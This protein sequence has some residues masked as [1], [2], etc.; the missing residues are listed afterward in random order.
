MSPFADTFEKLNTY[1]IQHAVEAKDPSLLNGK[2]GIAVYFFHLARYSHHSSY[3]EFAEVLMDDVYT[4]IQKNKLSS[5]FGEGLAGIAWAIDHLVQEQFVEA[6]IDEVLSEVDDRIYSFLCHSKKIEFG[7][8]EGI[9]GYLVYVIIR[10]KGHKANNKEI[11]YVFSQ[12]FVELINRLSQS[13]DEKVWRFLEP[14][15]FALD[16]DLPICLVLLGEARALN[17]Y[18]DKIERMIS[19]LAPTVLAYTPYQHVH[20]LFLSL[21]ILHL[22][23]HFDLPQWKQHA[24]TILSHFDAEA[25]LNKELKEKNLFLA[26]GLAG[27]SF[28]LNFLNTQLETHLHLSVAISNKIENSLF[29]RS[30]LESEID[31]KPNLGLVNGLAGIG[32]QYLISRQTKVSS[33]L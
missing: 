23:R 32:L 31:K 12:V 2:M 27:I 8:R 7:L 13:I 30:Q 20:K 9:L 11:D 22:L 29:L 24:I 17:L 14:P 1:L 6:D 3:Q 28:L 25:L 26:N 33:L 19:C 18:S 5:C 15:F 21:S 10:L 4:Q 16:W